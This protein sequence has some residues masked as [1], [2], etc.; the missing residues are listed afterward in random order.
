[1]GKFKVKIPP[2]E[3][4]INSLGL[5]PEVMSKHTQSFLATFLLCSCKKDDKK[6]SKER[7]F[8]MRKFKIKTPPE[9]VNINSFGF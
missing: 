4:K 6:H 5:K 9:E 8:I 3:V 2:E 7:F 1:M